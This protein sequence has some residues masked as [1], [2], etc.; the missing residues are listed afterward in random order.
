MDAWDWDCEQQ[1]NF[2]EENGFPSW[3][4]M[5]HSG[6]LKSEQEEGDGSSSHLSLG[7]QH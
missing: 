4:I 3:P 5:Y 1:E 2:L 6:L 7:Y